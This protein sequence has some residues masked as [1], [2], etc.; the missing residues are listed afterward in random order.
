MFWRIMLFLESFRVF[1]LL[2]LS[3]VSA[4]KCKE[5]PSTEFVLCFVNTEEMMLKFG[6]V[7]C[8]RGLFRYSDMMCFRILAGNLMGEIRM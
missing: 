2:S 8:S 1:E 5:Q 4:Y 3:I 7:Y 6:S